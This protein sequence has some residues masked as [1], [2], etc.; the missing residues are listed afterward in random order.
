MSGIQ[1]SDDMGKSMSYYWFEPWDEKEPMGDYIEQARK[2]FESD[3]REYL[4]KMADAKH[5]RHKGGE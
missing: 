1:G 5:D 3:L 2:Q 4:K